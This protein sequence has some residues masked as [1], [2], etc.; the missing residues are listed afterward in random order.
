MI[1]QVSTTLM[2]NNEIPVFLKDCQTQE[3][4]KKTRKKRLVCKWIPTGKE[5]PKI[6]AKW[7]EEVEE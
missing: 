6:M 3:Q 2:V 1:M 7:V 5:Y 4:A